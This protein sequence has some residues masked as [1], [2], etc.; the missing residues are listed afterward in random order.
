MQPPLTTR[1][2]LLFYSGAGN[3][4]CLAAVFREIF[5]RRDYCTLAFFERITRSLD[6]RTFQDFD[7]LGIGFP[8]YFRKTPAI[9]FETLRRVEGKGRKVFSFCTKG[10][11]SGNITR[12]I[13]LRCAS[14]GLV[15]AGHFEARMPGTDAL[16]LFARKGSL[17]EKI[18]KKMASQHLIRKV[19]QFVETVLTTEG[20][21]LPRPKWYTPIED[22][23][24][25]PLERKVTHDYRV[26]RQGYRVMEGRCTQ[27][28]LCV[29]GCPEGNIH[30]RDGRIFFG[31]RCDICLRCIHHCPTEAIQIGEKTL[32]TVRYRPFVTDDLRIAM[33]PRDGELE[34][35]PRE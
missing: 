5:R 24:I 21:P 34:A 7:I 6:P 22:W 29:K 14:S 31:D 23:V 26:F 11:Y 13:L 4:E 30:F 35:G 33:A 15:P 1:V 25:R 18:I 16:L 17:T 8:V 2:G 12:E 20:I 9:V 10:M 27:C 28:L 19:T 32:K 3:T